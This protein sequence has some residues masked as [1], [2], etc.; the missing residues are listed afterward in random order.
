MCHVATLADLD[1]RVVR[2][3]ATNCL[4]WTGAHTPKGYG[5]IVLGGKRVAVHRA[6][7]E[8][9][10]GP[11]PAGWEV[12]HVRSAGCI[13]RDCIEP[14]H[15]EAVTHAE[16]VARQ[17]ATIT[18]CPSGHEYTPENTIAGRNG[19]GYPSRQCRECKNAWR[20]THKRG[21]RR[22]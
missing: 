14:T 10:H 6:A 4:R 5:H 9:H 13:H 20:R 2:D 3:P 7:Y 8:R 19:R 18:H 12:D 1:R 22:G 15:L 21:A 17:V 11:I 16:N